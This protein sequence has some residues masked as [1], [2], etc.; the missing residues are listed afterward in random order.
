VDITTV[1]DD[2]VLVIQPVN[3]GQSQSGGLELVAAGRI[4]A[5]LDATLSGSVYY[6]ALDASNLGFDGKKST[7]SVANCRL[8]VAAA[9]PRAPRASLP[10]VR[11]HIALW[12]VLVAC[13]VQAAEPVLAGNSF[14]IR[15][16]RVFDGEKTLPRANVVVR[17][18]HIRALGPNARIPKGLTVIDGSG[19][20]LLPGFIDS[21]THVFPGAQAD[22]LRFGVTTEIDMFN[23]R[24]DFAKW[25]AQ[26][27][28][29][30]P[31]TVAD[32][33]SAGI[34]VSVPGGH[35][36]QWV[37]ED[38]P[39]LTAGAHASEF[40]AAR[41]TEGSDFIKLIIEDNAAL[42]PAHPLPTLQP[43]EAC[44]VIAAAKAQGKLSIAH[45]TTQSN[46]LTAIRCGVSGLAHIFVDAP[47]SDELIRVAKEKQVF[48]VST[49][50]LLDI[51]TRSTSPLPS[52][53]SAGQERSLRMT[54]PLIHSGD[55]ENAL[56]SAR[57]L[58]RAG[59]L[60]LAGTDAPAP[61]T[62]HGVSIH[63]EIANLARAGFTPE[64]ALAT[65]TSLPAQVFDLRD[66]GRVRVGARA[67]LV[68]VGGDPTK[69]IGDTLRIVGT[70]KNGFCADHCAELATLRA[71][72]ASRSDASI[73]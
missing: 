13:K 32:T 47:A 58:H 67:D 4:V 15:D 68:L 29:L 11:I 45:A 7:F 60:I 55:F 56:E 17:G 63:R 71:A 12:L 40:V 37:P 70:W 21:H 65:A 54:T 33:W 22:A 20:T 51:S 61:G 14:A 5:G 48:F 39:R 72:A 57:R 41:I 49:S 1:I 53:L 52:L 59:V 9:T 36:N 28:S 38:M 8:L 3:L 64:E 35:P 31:V 66:R 10:L 73:M 44:A 16:V 69:H 43:D 25:R 30:D 46:A 23:T 27:S 19:K 6:N 62:A 2:D 42:D 26:R 50:S 34:G 18:G 24:P